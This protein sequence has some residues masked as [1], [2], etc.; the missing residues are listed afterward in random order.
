MAS[1]QGRFS[2]VRVAQRQHLH[3]RRAL[4]LRATKRTIDVTVSALVLVLSLPAMAVIALAITL[5]SP[6]P[7][8][9][10][11]ERVGLRGRPLRM[12]KFRKMRHD[13][14]GLALTARN[15]S[16]LTRA[17]AFLARTRLDELPQFWNVLRGDMSLIGPRPEDPAF[18]A[19]RPG[20]YEEILTVRP[21]ISGLSQLAYA[22]ERAILSDDD[23]V[24][25]Y[26]AR[27]LPQ[28]C[29]LDR[30][31]VR[32]A[33]PLTDVRI[34]LWTL[35][36]VVLRVP[37]AVH[38]GTGATSSRRSPPADAPRPEP[39]EPAMSLARDAQGCER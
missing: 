6:G 9:Y 33:T 34:A 7:V 38:R 8:F 30:L 2:S 25:D 36:A 10:R 3:R 16:R 31:Y 23:P 26:L 28:K 39:V 5:E 20:D 19:E 12:L 37:V 18:V 22:D 32:R 11:A 24:G 21:G 15:D 27:V 35:A 29:A 13:A 14:R 1:P 4:L 17:G